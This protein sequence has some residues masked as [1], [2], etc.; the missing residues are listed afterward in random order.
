MAAELGLS[1]QMAA[2][3]LAWAGLVPHQV[4]PALRQF[5]LLVVAAALSAEAVVLEVVA[6]LV[7]QADQ[8]AQGLVVPELLIREAAVVVAVH[9]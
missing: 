5:T 2:T 3:L 4:S 9:L 1:G 8:A 7:V 6:E